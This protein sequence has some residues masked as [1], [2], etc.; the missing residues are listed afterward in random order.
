ME[1][2]GELQDPGT[3]QSKTTST[4]GPSEN[5]VATQVVPGEGGDEEGKKTHLSGG[6]KALV[7]RSN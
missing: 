2:K 6:M 5:K 4:S 3:C 1:E 7:R